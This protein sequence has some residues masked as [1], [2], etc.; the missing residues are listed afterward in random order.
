MKNGSQNGREPL[1]IIGDIHGYAGELRALLDKLGYRE[2]DGAYRHDGDRCVLFLGDFVDRGPRIR[3][4]LHI[5]RAMHAAGAALAYATPD[6]GGDWLR[7]HTHKNNEQHEATLEQFAGHEEEWRGHLEWFRTLPLWLEL[8]GL[9]AVHAAWDGRAV[10]RLGGAARMDDALLRAASKRGAQEFRDVE[11]LLKGV[12]LPLPDG[13]FFHDQRDFPR[14]SIRT[15]WWLPARG[16]SYRNIALQPGSNEWEIPELDAG[17]HADAVPGYTADERPVFNGHYW[18]EG[19]PALMAPNVAI[20]DYSVAKGGALTAYR[21]DGEQR[22]DA[23]KFVQVKAEKNVCE[24]P[25]TETG[26][27]RKGQV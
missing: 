13:H 25:L 5:V 12:E 2:H 15:K 11:T 16:T 19:E 1:D 6:G 18:L 27:V 14:H 20:L 10:A 26:D 7:K 9:R 8:P 21:W 3:E 24:N 4:T 23:R 17:E 22:L